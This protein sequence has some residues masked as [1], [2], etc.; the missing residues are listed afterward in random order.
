[1][2]QNGG[3]TRVE[4]RDSQGQEVE[5]K[6]YCNQE[7]QFNYSLGTTIALGRALKQLNK[8]DHE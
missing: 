7:D 2:A 4:L 3:Y 5:G 6:A 1:M 8:K